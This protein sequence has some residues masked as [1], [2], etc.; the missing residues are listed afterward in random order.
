VQREHDWQRSRREE[1]A[2]VQCTESR[3]GV[4][5]TSEKCRN[6]ND[7]T[8]ALPFALAGRHH[9]CA[10]HSYPEDMLMLFG[11]IDWNQVLM[12]GLIGGVIGGVVGLIIALTKKNE[13]KKDDKEKGDDYDGS[14]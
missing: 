12:K 10:S 8:S 9:L 14:K 5:Q 7:H 11:D 2:G 4:R 13:P 3:T 1:K 6:G